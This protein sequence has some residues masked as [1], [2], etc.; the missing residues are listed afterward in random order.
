MIAL[1]EALRQKYRKWHAASHTWQA[2]DR[3]PRKALRCRMVI[4]GLSRLA[5]AFI[6][7]KTELT[8]GMPAPAL[9]G[10]LVIHGPTIEVQRFG[11]PRYCTVRP[12]RS[13]KLSLD[14][15][16]SAA[17]MIAGFCKAGHDRHRSREASWG[18][19]PAAIIRTLRAIVARCKFRKFPY[20]LNA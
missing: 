7:P 20:N 8:S 9:S 12:T 19:P 5:T 18:A 11:R 1:A 6:Y 14:Q 13:S 2:N 16:A 17:I 3:E 15:S 4:E 10:T